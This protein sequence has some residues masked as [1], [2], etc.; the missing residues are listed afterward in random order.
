MTEKQA[1]AKT[2]THRRST[3]SRAQSTTQKTRSGSATPSRNKRGRTWSASGGTTTS[4]RKKS[5]A[6]K[7]ADG[8]GRGGSTRS[9]SPRINHN[10]KPTQQKYRDTS[11]KRAM[12]KVPA[13][14]DKVR[15]IPLG[16]V[17]EVGK[18][19]TVVEYGDDIIIFDAG[20][21][22]EEETTPGIDYILPNT[23]YLEERKERI[24]GVVIT[25]GH[26]DHIGGI[27][28]ILPRIGN[29]PIYTR[30]LTD[31]MIKKRQDEFPNMPKFETKVVEP[32][33]TVTLGKTKV[34]FFPVT[35]SIPDSMGAM[36]KT[37]QGNI[38]IS[39][40]L[41]LDHVDGE[42]TDVEKEVWGNIGKQ[43]NLLFIGDSTNAEQDGYS[44]PES[45]I[46]ENL[47]ELI[48]GID[49]RIIV[50]TF[51]SQFARLVRLIQIAE[52]FNRKVITEGRSIK[53]NI[54]IAEKAGLLK[55]NK[56]TIIPVQ[57][58]DNYPPDRI[59]IL[60]TGAQ[61]EEFAALMR[62]ATKKH[63]FVRFTP[64]DTVILS[65]SV[66]PGNELSVQKLKDNLYRN[67]VH[68]HHY[69]SSDVHASGHGRIEE[70]KWIQ[71]Q[72][73][74]RFFMPAYGFHSMLRRH[75]QKVVEDN[76]FPEENCIVADNGNI[77]DFAADGK[78]FQ[79]LKEKAPTDIVMVDGFS[80]GERQE[81]VLR[82]R[83]MLAQDGI[84][85]VIAAVDSRTGKV[86]KSPDII[87]RGFIYLR[88]SQDLLRQARYIAKKTIEDNTL[89][90][91]PFDAEQV[92][93]AVTDTVSKFLFQQ[94]A[95]RPMVLPVVIAV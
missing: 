3:Q 12:T 87:S 52:K 15:V 21:Q 79:I 46:V 48:R 89:R 5:P 34:E 51:A 92:K 28:Y 67:R 24:R 29:P 4:T 77:I 33:E 83:Q 37:K 10:K 18:N 27:P 64:R 16:G 91:H 58:I 40:D 78:S 1:R 95:K 65:S 7:S 63:K 55:I 45:K 22:F 94:T 14:G 82:D 49:G 25:H 20:F 59:L 54:E 56:D 75:A 70:L 8:R 88:E 13:L 71:K 26:L 30:A 93:N 86:Y 31:L 68:L 85:V 50:G 39:G 47:E 6:K 38:V 9:K 62:I 69:R 43:D 41:R 42:P 66:I 32:G 84:F 19:M 72:V 2:G 36:V 76:N 53:T 11:P 61:G 23:S 81:V 80:I 17:E 73:G 60:A 44:I 57:E 74:A 90:A 35:H